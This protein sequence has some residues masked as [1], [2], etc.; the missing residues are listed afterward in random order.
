[1]R[2]IF[3]NGLFLQKF[4]MQN[5][6]FNMRN[7]RFEMFGVWNTSVDSEQDP[8]WIKQNVLRGP[9]FWRQFYS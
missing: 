7:D 5:Q 6:S 9:W 2:V 1:M 8:G 4:A 3:G